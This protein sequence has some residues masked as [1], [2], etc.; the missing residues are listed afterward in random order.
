MFLNFFFNAIQERFALKA[1]D[2]VKIRAEYEMIQI[3]ILKDLLEEPT[4]KSFIDEKFKAKLEGMVI[5]DWE[6]MKYQP[7]FYTFVDKVSPM[8][9]GTE[10]GQSGDREKIETRFEEYLESDRPL[11]NQATSVLYFVDHLFER[12]SLS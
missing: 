1:I 7:L 9:N 5:A 4:V 3:I 10:T 8:G 11:E 12:Y 2:D 6:R